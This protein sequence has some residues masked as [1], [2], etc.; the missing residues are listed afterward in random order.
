[1]IRRAFT[2]I[3]LLVV[4]AIIA[5]LA[6]ILFPVFAQAKAA[7]K[8]SVALSNVK[9][10]GLGCLMYAGDSDDVFPLATKIEGDSFTTWQFMIQPYAKSYQVMLHPKLP[11]PPSDTNSAAW[12]YQTAAHFGMPTRGA[13]NTSYV[14]PSGTNPGNYYF[15]SSSQ[16]GGE[17]RLLEG[18]A[19]NGVEAGAS[20][21]YQAD[22]P[23]L[24]T[25]SV[26]NPSDQIMVT[27]AGGWDMTWGFIT[28]MPMNSYFSGG[29]WK[30]TTMNVTSGLNY[31]GPHARKGAKNS[32][33]GG[34]PTLPYPDGMTTYVAVDGSAKAKSWKGGVIERL[35]LSNGMVALK[36]LWPAGN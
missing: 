29:L 13:A 4:I 22:A 12:F 19:G 34:T 2:L 26:N 17:T 5:I 11:A 25:S 31:C 1:M 18:I 33:Y 20:W 32:G 23:S 21:A 10:L 16:T 9:Q 3:E 36:H 14:A 27:E 7:A 24:S 8:D 6:A 15:K 30:D 28:D 35:E